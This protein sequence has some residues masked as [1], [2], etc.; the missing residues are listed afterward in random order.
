MPSIR[1]ATAK[2]LLHPPAEGRVVKGEQGMD[3]GERVRV[4]P[5]DGVY[6]ERAK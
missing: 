6:L 3:V 2:R 1:T 4:N 5:R